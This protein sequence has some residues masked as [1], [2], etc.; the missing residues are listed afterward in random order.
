M[1]QQ[2]GDVCDALAVS[3]EVSVS[4]SRIKALQQPQQDW[5]QHVYEAQRGF[6]HVLCSQRLLRGQKDTTG[7][8]QVSVRLRGCLDDVRTYFRW[9]LC[10][11]RSPAAPTKCHFILTDCFNSVTISLFMLLAINPVSVHFICSHWSDFV[12]LL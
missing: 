2:A 11:L 1:K 6:R 5:K 10:A 12:Y 8:E 9:D 3:P 4:F 7:Q